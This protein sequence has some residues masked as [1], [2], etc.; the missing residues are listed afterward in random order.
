MEGN[1]EPWSKEIQ[2][3]LHKRGYL[4]E[5]VGFSSVALVEV[6]DKV[7]A[8]GYDGLGRI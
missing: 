1:S 8:I 3:G 4:W 6:Q 2:V 7:P 5:M